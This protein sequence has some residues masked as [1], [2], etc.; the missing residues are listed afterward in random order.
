[1]LVD[2]RT[3][4]ADAGPTF[5]ELGPQVAELGGSASFELGPEVAAC[6]PHRPSLAEAAQHLDDMGQDSIRFGRC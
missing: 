3:S 6:G 1:M 5:A 4:L 2:V